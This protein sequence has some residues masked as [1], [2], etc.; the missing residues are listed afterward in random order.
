MT[1]GSEWTAKFGAFT[2]HGGALEV[3]R[4]LE[5]GAPEPWI[6]LSTGISPYA[7]PLP[8]LD[9]EAWSRLPESGALAELEAVAAQR[10]R[11]AAEN[12]VAGAGS[13]A[14]IQALSHI[15]SR[16]A[17]G[18]LT[19]TYSGFATAFAAAGA[20]IVEAKRLEDM[21]D[22]DVAIVVNPNNPDGRIIS[23][24]PLLD[25]HERL[26][27]RGGVLIVD[28]AFADFNAGGESFAP[29]L[30]GSGAVVL[31]SFGK[32]YGL[33][34]LRLGFALTSPDMIQR[35]RAALGP[36]PVSGPA[37]AVGVRALGD[38]DWLEATR[39]RLSGDV[40]RLD[41][42]LLSAGWRIIG[43]A[44][45]FRLAGRPEAGA[46]FGRLLTAGILT[47]PFA[48]MSD[49]LRFGIPA[50]ESAW[51]RLGKALRE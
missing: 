27:R 17:V 11:V 42:L 50:D 44:S 16:G 48:D 1:A 31:R 23:R 26:A 47:R 4:R 29:S 25:L 21:G 19:P 30:P 15:L 37:I 10:Y 14:L 3:A 12:V 20:R 24:A 46:A 51:E 28:E 39:A 33:A 32:A 9:P 43:G 35:L 5:P 40:A 8:D 18:V 38:S 22:V 6:D 36:W 13:Q 2:Y 49:R 34:G 7:Y 45:L 41:A